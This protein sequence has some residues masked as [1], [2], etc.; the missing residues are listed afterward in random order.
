MNRLRLRDR[1]TSTPRSRS[2]VR[3][4]P[5]PL[6]STPDGRTHLIGAAEHAYAIAHRIGVFATRCGR[7]VLP[8]SLTTPPG[9]PCR[10]CYTPTS[11]VTSASRSSNTRVL[12]RSRSRRLKW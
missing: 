6:T 1:R 11:P 8:T 12:W 3:D 2:I 10:D 9:P 7:S 4:A 5:I